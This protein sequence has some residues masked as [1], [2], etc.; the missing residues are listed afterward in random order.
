M[1]WS[2]PPP[3]EAHPATAAPCDQIEHLARSVRCDGRSLD[4]EALAA[5][6]R[7]W[8]R[9]LARQLLLDDH[10]AEDVAQ[11]CVLLVCQRLEQWDPARPFRAWAAT[12]TAR[13]AIDHHRARTRRWRL[14]ERLRGRR[15]PATRPVGDELRRRELRAI[16]DGLLGELPPRQRAALVLRDL[17]GLPLREVAEGLGCSLGAAK[18][19]VSHG[20]RRVRDR[21]A[22]R[23]PEYLE[24]LL[25]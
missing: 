15:A 3:A 6:L 5:T 7:P 22:R 14:L 24:D 20:R 19:H 10:L 8:L 11:E 21:L 23:H 25:P 13:R 18:A 2:T 1:A 17:Q 9:G 4:L 16:L 12:L